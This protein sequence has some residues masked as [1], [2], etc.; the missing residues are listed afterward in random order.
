MEVAAYLKHRAAQGA[1]V[2]TVR[3]ALVNVRR[4]KTNQDGAAVDVR[5]T[6]NGFAAA[7]LA[8]RPSDA[9]PHWFVFG[10]LNGQ[11]IGRRFGQSIGRRFAQACK[12]AGLEGDYTG[13]SG[14]VGLA[15]ELVR[16]GA[17]TTEVQLAGGWR[18]QAMVARYSAG[19]AASQG[20]VAKYL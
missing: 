13:H 6:K 20:A 16:R 2:A 15:V 3:A 17:S 8:L 14:R 7:L 19:I 18:S 12:A 5:F 10:G 1:K 4:S 9:M 11:S